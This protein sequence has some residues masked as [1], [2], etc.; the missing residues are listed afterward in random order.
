VTGVQTIDDKDHPI[1]WV[2][3]KEENAFKA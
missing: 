3:N 1:L 2:S